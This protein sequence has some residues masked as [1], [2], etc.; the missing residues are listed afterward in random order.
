MP[1]RELL[2]KNDLENI[3]LFNKW[4]LE[5]TYRGL[6]VKKLQVTFDENY[7][8]FGINTNKFSLEAFSPQAYDIMVIEIKNL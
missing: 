3:I 1:R 2:L 8:V 6:T 5:S 4:F 7:M